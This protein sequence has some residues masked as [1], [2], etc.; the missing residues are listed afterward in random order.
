MQ[1]KQT[2]ITTVLPQQNDEAIPVSV[3]FSPLSKHQ[4][5]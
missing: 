3:P 2:K 1:A 5:N 4:G